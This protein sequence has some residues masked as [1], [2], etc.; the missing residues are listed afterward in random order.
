MS[1]SYERVIETLETAAEENRVS[2]LRVEQVV[3]LP[4]QG[5]AWMTGDLHDHRRNFAKL[6]RGADLRS[7]PERHLIVHE[8]IH[9]DH[10]E[11]DGSESSWQ[12]L[13]AAA[14]LKC[15]FPDQVHFLLANHDLAQIHGEG[16]LKGGASVCEAFSKG[17]AKAFGE[18]ADR[19]EVAIKDFLLSLPLAVRLPNGIFCCHSL[20]TDQQ[21]ES[22]DFTVFNRQ[23]T[24]PDY[25]RRTGPVYQ[26]IWGRNMSPDTAARFAESVGAGLLITGH[27][28]Q[29]GGYAVNGPQHLILSSDHNRGVFL[30]IDPA[31]TYTMEVLVD[32][33]Q[34]FAAM[35][36]DEG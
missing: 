20:P 23:L 36:W 21:I 2:A 5:E 13:Y 35:E 29:E 14:D 31:T 9:G 6:V 25:A 18:H 15:D 24:G 34:P 33:L 1:T 17:V 26:L 10:Y 12:T 28:P 7:H 3:N 11:P 22:F 19:V 8:L 4:A 16:I 27:Q 32:R 30:P